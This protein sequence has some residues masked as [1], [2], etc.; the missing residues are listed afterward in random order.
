MTLDLTAENG[1]VTTG[2]CLLF[3][4]TRD[5]SVAIGHPYAK[6]SWSTPEMEDILPCLCAK[7]KTSLLS[8][9]PESLR[10]IIDPLLVLLDIFVD[11]QFTIDDFPSQSPETAPH[12]SGKKMVNPSFLPLYF[13]VV[14]FFYSEV[15]IQ[16][17]LCA[18]GFLII[19]HHYLDSVV[20]CL[21]GAHKYLSLTLNPNFEGFSTKWQFGVASLLF[22]VSILFS[23]FA[24]SDFMTL[25]A[26]VFLMEST[27]AVCLTSMTESL[28]TAKI[29]VPYHCKCLF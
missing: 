1:V 17:L 18:F 23:M 11:K 28:K 7:I 10:D 26:G 14:S 21:V 27:I 19:I 3:F 6:L 22:K 8:S 24:R 12:H 20:A 29:D 25:P 13:F 16:A 2:V 5:K 4:D 15:D 9:S